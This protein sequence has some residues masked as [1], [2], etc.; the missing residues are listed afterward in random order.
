MLFQSVYPFTGEVLEQHESLTP[1]QIQ[2]KLDIAKAA[3]K[4]WRK[5]RELAL[6]KNLAAVLRKNLSRDA[7]LITL[8]TGKL[9]SESKLE[10]EK[11]A[12]CCEYYAENASTW[13][14]HKNLS[15]P[16]SYL[17]AEPLGLVLGVMPWNFPFWQIIRFSVGA[18]AAGNV[19]LV[20]HAPN[21]MSCSK[22][23]EANF[24]EAG[25]EQGIYQHFPL[26]IQDV[27]AAIREVDA[28]SFTG[29]SQT[30]STLA[31][32]AAA[33]LKKCVLELGGSDA[34][35]V[36]SDADLNKAA[37]TAV[38]S[39]LINAGQSCIAAKRFIVE[40]SVFTE[41]YELVEQKVKS[42]KVSNPLLQETKL[43]P[44]ARIDLKENLTL[45]L[46]QALSQS[47]KLLYQAPEQQGYCSFAPSIILDENPDPEEFFGPV[48][49]FI[50]AKNENQ[51]VELA[52]RSRYGLGASVWTSDSEKARKLAY[53]LQT[54]NVFVNAMV[55]SDPRLPF[56]GVKQSGYGK[57]LSDLGFYEFCN[58]KTIV[59]S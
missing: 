53:E 49:Q 36:L 2:T 11:C 27:P 41:F 56:G 6:F 38:E 13:L 29:S 48:F 18:I 28:L 7:K 21:T 55:R 57:E 10:I 23:L 58:L 31:Q 15:F 37:Q 59:E 19:V 32:L 47:A 35:I 8:E 30:G 20:K 51:A 14:E 3:Q 16:G 40:E 34:F 52:N 54:G 44:L 22:A 17:R 12:I 9:I 43:A 26:Q 50:T 39:R 42:L 24:I 4:K 25:F 1:E 45:Q 5:N 46:K 33:H